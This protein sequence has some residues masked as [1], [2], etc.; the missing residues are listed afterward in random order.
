LRYVKAKI[1]KESEAEAYRFYISEELR[2]ITNNCSRFNGGVEIKR[3]FAE[4]LNGMKNP[5]NRTAEE[6]IDSMK[7]KL[8]AFA[9]S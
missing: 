7:K 9:E 3:T 5:D 4:V 1:E 8:Q 2:A 6:V